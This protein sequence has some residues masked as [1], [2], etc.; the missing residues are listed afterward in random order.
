[1]QTE[2]MRVVIVGGGFGGVAAAQA[3]LRACPKNALITLIDKNQYHSLPFDFYETATAFLDEDHNGK[4][5]QADFLNL[6]SSAMVPFAELFPGEAIKIIH[7]VV[8]GIDFKDKKVLTEHNFPPDVPYDYLV[9]ALGSET[10]YF[11]I[12]HLNERALGL[13]TMN[14]ALNIRNRIDEL[15]ANTPKGDPIGI[16]IGGG[17]YTG[18]ELAGEL[19]G[20]CRKLA[21]VHGHPLGNIEIGILEAEDVLV[22]AG[23]PWLQRK[24]L[25]RLEKMG[26][27]VYTKCRIVDVS[28]TALTVEGKGD[29]PYSLLIWTAGVKS[30]SITDDLPEDIKLNKKACIVVDKQFQI[31]GAKDAYAVGD[32]AYYSMG[33]N[34]KSLAQTAQVAISEGRYV[35]RRIAAVLKKKKTSVFVPVYPKFVVPLGEKYAVADLGFIQFSGFPAWMLKRLISLRYL[36]HLLPWST[37]LRKWWGVTQLYSKND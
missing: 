5:E 12:P 15:F 27:Q 25:A 26:V 7:V 10:N 14:D 21:E 22:G 33:E 23:T 4:S 31:K 28:E 11:N 29:I 20:Y 8:T 34:K 6:K 18:C 19:V 16:I 1:M 3:L 17:G 30:H 36:F 32:I 9:L 37:A 2:K 13:K 35:G 24:T